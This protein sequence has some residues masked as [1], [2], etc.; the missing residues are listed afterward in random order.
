MIQMTNGN[1]LLNT[2]FIFFPWNLSLGEKYY[3]FLWKIKKKKKNKNHKIL[4]NGRT[5]ITLG[6]NESFRHEF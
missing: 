1:T 2:V 6:S 3:I 5:D 4:T